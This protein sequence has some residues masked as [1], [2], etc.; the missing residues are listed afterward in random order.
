MISQ[1]MITGDVQTVY[2]WRFDTGQN[3]CRR[4]PRYNH[5]VFFSGMHFFD[6]RSL[7]SWG[8]VQKQMHVL[9]NFLSSFEEVE[10]I[11]IKVLDNRIINLCKSLDN[12]WKS[13]KQDK[14]K[15]LT[16][17]S[18]WLNKIEQQNIHEDDI[19]DQPGSSRGRPRKEFS[20]L[21]KRSKRR[22]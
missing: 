12:Y 19:I 11:D 10:N 8:R 3:G 14:S 20:K 18:D 22:R 9:E 13:V 1:L 6:I 15:L 4:F 7:K 17:Y 16:K 21:S 2:R 5:Q